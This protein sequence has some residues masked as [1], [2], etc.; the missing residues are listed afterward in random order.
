MK[1]NSLPL[2]SFLSLAILTAAAA[3]TAAEFTF[4]LSPPGADNAVGLSPLNETPPVTNSI[5]SGNE[6]APGISF[7][8]VTSNLNFSIGYGSASG[9]INL[10]GPAIGAQIHG[11]ATT[12]ASAP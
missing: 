5:G 11:P 3:A 4:D 2:A 1:T 12:N 9:F 6:I 10:T 7:D 8:T